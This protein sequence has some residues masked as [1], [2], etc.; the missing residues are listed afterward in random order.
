MAAAA[1]V[2]SPPQPLQGAL[3][4][5]RRGDGQAVPACAEANPGLEKQPQEVPAVPPGDV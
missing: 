4:H 3:K 2:R 5:R 1:P